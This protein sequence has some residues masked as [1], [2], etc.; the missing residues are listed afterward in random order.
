MVTAAIAGHMGG[1]TES[2]TDDPS[3]M[4]EK[5]PDLVNVRLP[6]DDAVA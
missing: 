4:I 5:L 6:A 3:A 2:A 1:R